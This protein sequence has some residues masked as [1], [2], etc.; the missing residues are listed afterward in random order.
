MS[1]VTRACLCLTL[2][3]L[4]VA[5]TCDG[6]RVG[7]HLVQPQVPSTSD[8]VGS[9]CSTDSHIHLN[10]HPDGNGIARKARGSWFLVGFGLR[11]E[12]KAKFL[13][14]SIALRVVQHSL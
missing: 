14:N 2:V 8:G 7:I 11:F 3:E 1:Q 4:A 9:E 12:I 10:S 5:T 13:Q 6:V